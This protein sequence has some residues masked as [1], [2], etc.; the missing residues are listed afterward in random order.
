MQKPSQS[1]RI[2]PDQLRAAA[3]SNRDFAIFMLDQDGKVVSW[4]GAAVRTTGHS[5]DEVMGLSFNL[6][7]PEGLDVVRSERLMRIAGGDGQQEEEGW[8]VRKDGSR[9][10]AGVIVTSLHSKGGALTGFLAVIE[11]REEKLRLHSRVKS[12]N[13]A[14]VDLIQQNVALTQQNAQGTTASADGKQQSA[15]G[16]NITADLEAFAYTV[17]HDLREPLR[18]IKSFSQFLQEDSTSLDE[19]AKDHI[20]RI[21]NATS[22][23]QSMLDQLLTYAGLGTAPSDVTS[24]NLASLIQDVAEAMTFTIA[25]SHA[26]LIVSPDMPDIKGERTR[27]EEV[28]QNLISNGIKFNRSTEP[29]IWIGLKSVDAISATIYVKDNGI[30]IGK[31]DLPR[32]FAM[33]ERLQPRGEFEGTGAGLAIV[34]RA[35]ES[36]GGSIS[37]ESTPGAGTTFYLTLPLAEE[38]VARAA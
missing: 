7:F 10:W 5:S 24:E 1:L 34:K 23:M 38:P 21:V 28:F 31:E 8:C 17:S 30:G 19:D 9:F 35:I 18:T 3:E 36:M 6:F 15:G 4:N 29:T 11:D 13:N 33:F 2:S 16:A 32:L 25:S 12:L 20:G 22:R 37:A 27:L 26:K 14:N